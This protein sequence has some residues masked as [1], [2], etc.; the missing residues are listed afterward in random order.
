MADASAATSGP[1]VK[2][3]RTCHLADAGGSAVTRDDLLMTADDCETFLGR[4]AVHATVEEKVDGANLGISIDKKTQQIMFQ[5]RSHFVNA[6]TAAQWR[7]VLVLVL[8]CQSSLQE[9]PPQ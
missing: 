3:P 1:T 4:G 9:I 6:S 7:W 8:T 5:N 2:C